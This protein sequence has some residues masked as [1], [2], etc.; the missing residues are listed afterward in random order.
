M[1]YFCQWYF[2]K[3]GILYLRTVGR[4]HISCV[5]RLECRTFRIQKV[6]GLPTMAG[7]PAWTTIRPPTD[8]SSSTT[9]CPAIRRPPCTTPIRTYSRPVRTGRTNS[10]APAVPL[11]PPPEATWPSTDCKCPPE[12]MAFHR[13]WVWPMDRRP[14]VLD[15]RSVMEQIRRWPPL[16]PVCRA[17]HRRRSPCPAVRCP[18]RGRQPRMRRRRLRR[19]IR[20]RR[21]VHSSGWPRTHSRQP[22]SHWPVLIRF[23]LLFISFACI[24]L[25]TQYFRLWFSTKLVFYM[26]PLVHI[27]RTLYTYSNVVTRKFD[28]DAQVWFNSLIQCSI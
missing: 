21:R 25:Y 12:R 10:A 6:M 28:F 23:L 11:P 5:A 18:V 22:V 3:L 16:H 20:H 15:R 4:P 13:L 27:I 17:C 9:K 1:R 14:L 24:V 2:A 8:S 26:V 7:I 19:W